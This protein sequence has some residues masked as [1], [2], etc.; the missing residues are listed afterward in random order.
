MK[1]FMNVTVK[2]EKTGKTATKPVLHGMGNGPIDT[3]D[4][5]LLLEA[6]RI[7]SVHLVESADSMERLLPGSPMIERLRMF[8]E[9]MTDLHT[10]MQ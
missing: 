4:D 10:R 9:S 2:T 1:E 3:G 8:A 5:A 7:A 6:L